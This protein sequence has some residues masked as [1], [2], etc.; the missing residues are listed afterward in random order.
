MKKLSKL[1]ASIAIFSFLLVGCSSDDDIIRKPDELNQTEIGKQLSFEGD[2]QYIHGGNPIPFSFSKTKIVMLMSQMT[3]SN[4][5][6]DNYNI[7]SI[8]KNDQAILKVVAKHENISEYKAFYFKNITEASLDINIDHTFSSEIEAIEAKYPSTGAITPDHTSNTFGW[9]KL[10]KKSEN[11]NPI[12]L[13]IQGKY[14]FSQQGHTYSYSFAN[15]KV[16]F[17][18]SYDMSV[19][20]HNTITNKILLEGLGDKAGTFYVIQI[21]GI[22][23]TTVDIARNTYGDTDGE[24]KAQIEFASSEEIQGARFSTYTKENTTSAFAELAG[25]YFSEKIGD[26]I[27]Y[28]QFN[29]NT[30]EESFV[31]M[32]D[33]SST[34]NFSEGGKLQLKKVYE[35]ESKDQIIFEILAS[36]GYYSGREGQFLTL[37]VKDYKDGEKATFAIATKGGVTSISTSKGNVIGTTLEEAKALAAPDA[38]KIWQE[39]MMEYA[40]VWISTTKK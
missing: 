34:G 35:D 26:D 30:N 33:F 39:N 38:L 32:A 22:T 10:T 20:R 13:P 29:I 17:N 40:H 24:S 5:E 4:Q 18:D 1:F 16:N 9:L 31:F 7:I 6:D 3:G 23:N 37:Y 14:I 21:K 15:D 2:Y 8:Y 36:N 11:T 25:S 28:Y 27:G 19:I 12:N